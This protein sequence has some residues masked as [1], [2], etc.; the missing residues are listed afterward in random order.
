MLNEKEVY[1]DEIDLMELLLLLKKNIKIIIGTFIIVLILSLGLAINKRGKIEYTK[2]GS[3]DIKVISTVAEYPLNVDYNTIVSDKDFRA[4]FKNPE[5]L[6]KTTF[7][8]ENGKFNLSISNKTQTVLD[9]YEEEF[10]SNL[11]KYLKI[12]YTKY[13]NDNLEYQTKKMNDYKLRLDEGTS[14]IEILIEK[15]RGKYNIEELKEVH[16]ILFSE[17]NAIAKIYEESYKQVAI[18]DDGIK[19][20]DVSVERSNE[21]LEL[22]Q[23]SSKLILIVGGVLGLFLGVFLVFIKEFLMGIDWKKFKDI[24]K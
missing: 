18:I 14:K 6:D 20:F 16:P 13:L 2:K 9:D 11:I 7:K 19:K 10:I 1:E 17:K 8:N 12:K 22:K 24:K 15:N 23:T 4:Y 3:I 5:I 21:T